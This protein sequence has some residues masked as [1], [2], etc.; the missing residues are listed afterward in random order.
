MDKKHYGS[1]Y[2]WAFIFSM[3]IV[4]HYACFLSPQKPED[5]SFL[6]SRGEMAFDFFFILTGVWL[7][8]RVNDIPSDRVFEWKETGGF[9]RTPLR[10]YFP[11]L[12]ICWIVTFIVLNVLSRTDVKTLVNYFFISLLELLPVRSA[13]FSVNPP[14]SGTVVGYCIMDQV[15]ALSAIFI[16]LAI[17]YPLYRLDRKRFEYYIAPVGAALL[18]SFLFFKKQTLCCDEL[19]ILNGKKGLYFSSIGTYKAI[20]EILAGVAVYVIARHF[21][22]KT[23]TKKQAHLLSVIEIGA[24]LSAILYMQLMQRF[25]LPKRFDFLCAGMILLGI[26]VS[27]GQKS[28]VSRLFDHRLFRFLGRFS[29]YP[30]LTFI[31]F[32]KTL[33][34]FL[35]DLS[36]RMLALIYIALTLAFA[37][38]LMALE[39]PFVKLVRSAK[40]LIAVSSPKEETT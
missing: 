6:F 34:I 10:R 37:L 30:F 17:L 25:D 14:E 35:P 7:A 38:L 22:E 2:F 20:G 16:A 29:L 28:S 5:A 13:G 32:A 4:L 33:P 31:L 36:A 1:L 3:I 11:A 12:L 39:K 24:Y 8:K 15:W 9:L 19:L 40:K 18:M 21:S 27:A 26:A 23:V